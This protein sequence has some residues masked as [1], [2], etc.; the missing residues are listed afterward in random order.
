VDFKQHQQHFL[1]QA[2]RLDSKK[3]EPLKPLFG[4]MD[5]AGRRWFA[6]NVGPVS[7]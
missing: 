6:A 4:P 1:Q 3:L 5:E 2:A 7:C